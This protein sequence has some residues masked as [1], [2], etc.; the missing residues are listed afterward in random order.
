MRN[1][2]NYSIKPKSLQQFYATIKAT[3][4][5]PY[6]NMDNVLYCCMNK[7]ITI[8]DTV[9]KFKL[10]STTLKPGLIASCKIWPENGSGPFHT[11]CNTCAIIIQ[12]VF[13]RLLKMGNI[14]IFHCWLQSPNTKQ[15]NYN[16]KNSSSSS[17]NAKVIPREA[18]VTEYNKT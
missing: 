10:N 17:N 14:I 8:S 15:R 5:H 16:K 11:D 7:S 1:A 13:E 3:T 6:V 12:T 9:I 18:T 2:N 4:G